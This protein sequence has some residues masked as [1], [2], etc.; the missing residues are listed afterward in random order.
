MSCFYLFSM[1]IFL[2]IPE[3]SHASDDRDGS[4]YSEGCDNMEI[5]M[6]GIT[7][8][9]YVFL[10]GVALSLSQFLWTFSAVVITMIVGRPLRS[11]G[12]TSE[13]LK[14]SSNI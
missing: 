9:Q 4:F 8:N 13:E 2:A 12:Y 11:S 5:I 3:Y 10:Y 14:I 1:I 6:W 7:S